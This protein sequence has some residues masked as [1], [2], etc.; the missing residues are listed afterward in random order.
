MIHPTLPTATELM[1]MSKAGTAAQ[2]LLHGKRRALHEIL[3]SINGSR[4]HPRE[5]DKDPQASS[6]TPRG[7]HS[8]MRGRC[9]ITS[10][11][12]AALRMQ[13]YALVEMLCCNLSRRSVTLVD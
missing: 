3:Q 6:A 11:E 8:S 7:G 12:Q 10:L 1:P 13:F 9:G 2:A 5:F 4:V